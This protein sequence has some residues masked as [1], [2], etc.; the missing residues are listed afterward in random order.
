MKR[1]QNRTTIEVARNFSQLSIQPTKQTI[2]STRVISQPTSSV[3]THPEFLKLSAAPAL[4]QVRTVTKYSM[5]SGKRKAVKAVLKRF[6]RLEWGIWV[7]TM[8][9]RHKRIWKK[10]HKR[11]Y[12]ARQ[13]VFCNSTQSWL[14]DSMVTRFW[15]RPKYY[16]DDPYRPFHKR[17]DHWA[18]RKKPIEWEL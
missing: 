17:E 13:H 2:L 12:K 18:T 5:K 14:L 3:L 15:R 10:S 9:G 6:K 16:V 7:R 11:R 4:T 1:I 8:T